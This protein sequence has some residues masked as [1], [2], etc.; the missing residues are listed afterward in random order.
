MNAFRILALLV[1]ASCGAAWAPAAETGR[2]ASPLRA[3]LAARASYV[4]GNAVQIEL[5]LENVASEPVAV[6]AWNTP[7]ERLGGDAL[8]LPRDGGAGRFPGALAK[9]GEP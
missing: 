6:L 8:R 3:R 1:L 7:F 4:L 2:P 5:T 9:R